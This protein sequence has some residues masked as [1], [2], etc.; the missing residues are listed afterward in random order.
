MRNLLTIFLRSFE[1]VAPKCT[2]VNHT[3]G[4]ITSQLI[5][6]RRLY[7]HITC[8][9]PQSSVI[10]QAEDEVC[11]TVDRVGLASKC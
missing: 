3:R 8:Q 6:L 9:L 7:N 1:N 11:D 5:A 4:T 2:S 10:G